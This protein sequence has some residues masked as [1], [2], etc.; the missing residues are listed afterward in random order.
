M[1]HSPF[2]PACSVVFLVTL[3]IVG[4]ESRSHDET[5]ARQKA[6]TRQRDSA[7]VIGPAGP[8]PAATSARQ[9]SVG[10]ATSKVRVVLTEWRIRLSPDTVPSGQVTFHIVNRGKEE[11]TIELEPLSGG[12]DLNRE[13][14][15]IPPGEVATL[16]YDLPPGTWSV[17][18]PISSRSANGS[19]SRRGMRNTLVVR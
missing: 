13:G 8:G 2:R 19:H 10:E 11:H 6:A 15:E 5:T 1:Q 16:T 14:D 17:D 7:A 12:D 4:C 18:C 9:P 3:A